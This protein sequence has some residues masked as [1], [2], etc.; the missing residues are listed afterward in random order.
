MHLH[1]QKF[2]EQN[3]LCKYFNMHFKIICMQTLLHALQGIQTN[4]N[5][6]TS[7]VLM[8]KIKQRMKMIW[9]QKNK[10]TPMN[11]YWQF[12]EGCLIRK[13]RGLGK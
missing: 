1:L 2:H 7:N 12:R 10:K 3:S 13:N 6:H 11:I 9:G 4:H 5:S 8:T